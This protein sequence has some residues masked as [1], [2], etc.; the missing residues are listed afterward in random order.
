MQIQLAFENELQAQKVKKD[1]DNKTALLLQ[2]EQKRLQREQEERAERDKEARENEKI[3]IE[4]E[5]IMRREQGI[6][7]INNLK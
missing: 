6:I 4:R 7:I 1:E 3:R 2:A 5:E